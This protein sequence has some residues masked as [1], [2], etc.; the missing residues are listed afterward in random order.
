MLVCIF[1][2]LLVY[3][4]LQNHDSF[5][6][7]LT[8]LVFKAGAM[9]C[10]DF[11]FADCLDCRGS[12][13]LEQWSLL[14]GWYY[15]SACSFRTWSNA[16]WST[17]EPPWTKLALFCQMWGP[18]VKRRIIS[19]DYPPIATKLYIHLLIPLQFELEVQMLTFNMHSRADTCWFLHRLI[20]SHSK[21]LTHA[22]N[23]T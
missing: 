3:T 2:I 19:R 9:S 4:T 8:C 23:N 14:C 13:R 6:N 5:W 20:A 1:V 15:Q 22:T 18:F 21:W 17:Q 12:M 10:H 16:Q 11:I 7:A